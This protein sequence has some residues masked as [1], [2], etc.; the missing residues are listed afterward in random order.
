M[1]FIEPH[2]AQESS[3][4]LADMT[5]CKHLA[6][7]IKSQRAPPWPAPPTPQLPPRHIADELIDRYLQTVETVY[8]ILHVPSFK[9][10]YDAIWAAPDG[11]QPSTGF[12]VQLKLVLALGAVTYDDTCSLRPSATKWIYEAQ[13]YL[14]EPVYKSRL[15]IQTLQ[16]RVL[17]LLAQEL[18]D[19]SGDS[20]WIAVGSVMRMAVAMGLHR[21]PSYL[22]DMSLFQ[23]E[24]RRR[25]WNTILELAVQTSLQIGGPPLLTTRDFDA[26]APGNF[27]DETL[28]VEEAAPRPDAELT[29]TTVARAL[30]KTFPV[31]LKLAQTLNDLNTV[32]DKYEDTVRLDAEMRRE[33]K[34]MRQRLQRCRS[35]SSS[36]RYSF[37][38]QTT[39]FIM[40]RAISSLHAPYF[41]ASLH[42]TAYAFSRKVLMETSLK[43]WCAVWP[44]S[45]VMGGTHAPS[46]NDDLFSRFI[47]CGGGF[48]HTAAFRAA[49]I[50]SEELRGQLKEDEGLLG[51]GRMPL[52]TDLLAVV[53]EAVAWNLRCVEAGE[54]SVKGHL[55]ASLLCAN[56]NGVRQGLGK[57][58]LDR[59]LSMAAEKAVK[60]GLAV[61]EDIA[62]KT[63]AEVMEV[64]DAS[65]Q[66]EM[67]STLMDGWDLMVSQ[68]N[69]QKMRVR[70]SADPGNRCPMPCSFPTIKARWVGLSETEQCQVCRY[71][72]YFYS[73][74]LCIQVSG[75]M[76]PKCFREKHGVMKTNG[77]VG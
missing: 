16:T 72:N 64:A 34:E 66:M 59:C 60:K 68:G 7:S 8:R 23:A 53:K 52:R 32:M 54:T 4:A 63:G 18:I 6:R 25:L 62:R 46:P 5:K 74:Y 27:D 19:V 10:D 58:E 51:I 67:P 57:E 22:P 2:F 12:L 38:V 48:F 77:Q 73:R 20:V 61:L 14:S 70:T 1:E 11:A 35:L 44:S 30:R 33:F 37:A 49:F 39:D 76:R 42:E 50:L 31:R 55:V 24:M 13:T 21:D 41:A 9:R 69:M 45:A 3:Q 36:P 71:G 56:I 28:L 75:P 40:H 65:R 47:A 15:G 26:E 17:M 43:I 29:D